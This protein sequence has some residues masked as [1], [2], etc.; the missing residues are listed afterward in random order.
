MKNS[1]RDEK[2]QISEENKKTINE[3]VDETLKWLDDHQ[4]DT[5][6]VY[7]NKLKELQDKLTPILTSATG[8]LFLLRTYLYYLIQINFITNFFHKKTV[9]NFY[10][11][12][13]SERKTLVY[14]QKKYFYKNFLIK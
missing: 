8:D 1:I 12:K 7:E 6:D 9:D 13:F 14:F 5:K 10:A 4:N 3:T 11:K 2:I